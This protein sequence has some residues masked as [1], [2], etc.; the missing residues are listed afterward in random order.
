MTDIRVLLVDDHRILREG[1]RSLLERQEGIEVVG[2]AADGLE[3]IA[4]VRELQPD[5]VVMDIAMPNMDGLEATA[6]IKGEHP[7]VHILVLTQYED[8]HFVL[9]L[10]KAGA[11]GYLLKHAGRQEVLRGIRNVVEEGAF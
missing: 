7:Q 8:Q 9:P 1:L 5:V 3:A 2:E 10:L 11:S 6:M 4:K